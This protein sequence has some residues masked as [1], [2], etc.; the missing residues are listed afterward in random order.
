MPTLFTAVY[1]IG[2]GVDISASS[3]ESIDAI[4]PGAVSP[5]YDELRQ[6]RTAEE[7]AS[8]VLLPSD[9]L[10]LLERATRTLTYQRQYTTLAAAQDRKTWSEANIP[11]TF[12]DF[13]RG[14]IIITEDMAMTSR[15]YITV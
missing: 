9:F 10:A 1:N 6:Q 12:G 15:G 3:A 14:D 4:F 5:E 11:E 2:P 7:I 8:G 13:F